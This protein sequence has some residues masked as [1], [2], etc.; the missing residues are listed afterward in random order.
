M[1]FMTASEVMT[2]TLDKG[3]VTDAS[4][5][6]VKLLPGVRRRCSGSRAASGLAR[7]IV[8]DIKSGKAKFLLSTGDFVWWGKQGGKPSDNPYWKL[9]NEDV[10][11]QLPHRTTRCG[12]PAS[13][14]AFSRPSAITR[15]GTTP[16]SKVS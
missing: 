9:V 1:P 5:E 13:T 4:V 8:K 6:D 10:L 11:K 12:Q 15:C 2:L 16:T 7:E 14:G 3:W